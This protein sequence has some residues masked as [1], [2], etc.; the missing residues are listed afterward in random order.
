VANRDPKRARKKNARDERSAALAAQ[1]RRRRAARIAGILAFVVV[2]GILVGSSLG[3]ERDDGA[4]QGSPKTQRAPSDACPRAEDVP[5]AEPQ[6]YEAPEDVLED[7][8]DYAAVVRTSCGD[9]EIDLLEEKAPANVNSFAF[10]AREGFYDG[11]VFHRVEREFVIQAGDP[12]GQNGAEP[13]G[14][15]YTLPDELPDQPSEYVFGVVGMANAG[16]DTGG[17][18][19]FIITYEAPE[20]VESQAAG[21]PRQFTI[22]GEVAESSY[23]TIKKI[24]VQPTRGGDDPVEASKPVDPI[25]ILGIDIIER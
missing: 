2:L 14:P 15:G 20:G 12:N 22:F 4:P 1:F 23:E 3:D 10:L 9:I 5:E 21:L 13:D 17:S 7:G 11:L 6:Q 18:Q 8:V 24:D 16:P 19:F 25:Y